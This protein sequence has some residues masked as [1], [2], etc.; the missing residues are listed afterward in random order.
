MEILLRRS[1]L[2][3]FAVS[4]LVG[5]AVIVTALVALA[6]IFLDGTAL[7]VVLIVLVLFW[8]LHAGL[9]VFSW[10]RMRRVASPLGLHGDGLHARS[11]FGELIAPWEAIESARIERAWNGKRLRIRLVPATDGRF[12]GIVHER[13]DPRMFAIVQEK[14]MRY[15][16]RVLDIDL[17]RLREAFV[18]QSGGR[19]QIT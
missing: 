5:Y 18:V 8:L 2:D 10:T 11:Q 1:R 4:L 6:S 12:A 9:Y 16:L 7:L 15:S 3:A 13:L 17:D 19:L 14:G